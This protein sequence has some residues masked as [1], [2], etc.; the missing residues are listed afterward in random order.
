MDIYYTTDFENYLQFEKRF[1]IHTTTAYITDIAQF[2]DY[3]TI[4]VHHKA[5]NDITSKHIRTWISFLAQDKNKSN[6]INRKISTL[7]TYYK[8]L[9]RNGYVSI[10]PMLKIIAPKQEKRLPQFVEESRM[11][12]LYDYFAN[13]YNLDD[14]KDYT[15]YLSFNLF[16]YT[17]ARLSEI[18]NLQLLDVNLYGMTI[19]VLGKR[20]KE[21]QIPLTLDMCNLLKKYLGI[22]PNVVHN[23]LLIDDKN[24]PFTPAKM[25][26]IIKQMLSLIPTADRK[27]PHVLRHTFATHMLNEGADINAIK[28]MMGHANLS[29]TQIYTHNSIDKLKKTYN[30]AHPK[31]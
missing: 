18:I 8:F 19:K 7:K 16:Y 23:Q 17:G 22:R 4:N 14:Y 1:S 12:T 26:K 25:G 28:E 30:L 29:A 13:V 31:A 15:H 21:R 9:M 20:N 3:I 2:I 5:I 6:T 11:E 24:K 27:S 10:N